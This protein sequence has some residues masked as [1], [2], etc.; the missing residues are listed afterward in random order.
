LRKYV[1]SREWLHLAH[2]MSNP[3]QFRHV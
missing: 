3:R 2:V 1:N